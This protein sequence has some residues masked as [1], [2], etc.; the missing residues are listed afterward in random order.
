MN[1]D[2]VLSDLR[3]RLRAAKSAGRLVV[4]LAGSQESEN[5]MHIRFIRIPLAVT[6]EGQPATSYIPVFTSPED[7]ILS[8]LPADTECVQP[9][10]T[11]LLE[12]LSPTEW[13]A[14]NPG[15]QMIGLTLGDLARLWDSLTSDS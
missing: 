12:L 8:G 1:D 11:N 15:Q 10:P 6:D 2:E 13:V 7:L 9:S 5:G 14:V 4:P 3:T